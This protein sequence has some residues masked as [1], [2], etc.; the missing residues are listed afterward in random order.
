MAGRA[1]RTYARDSRGR[2][3][4]GGGGGG[5]GKGGGKKA[6][7]SAKP[8]RAAGQS[9]GGT[10]SARS[11]LRKSREKLA[12]N[13]TKAQ[14][15]AVT[16]ASNRLAKAKKEA[17]V[18]LFTRFK[19]SGTMRGKV[20]RDPGAL[21][22]RNAQ[23][24][25]VAKSKAGQRGKQLSRTSKAAPSAAK[26]RYKELSTTIRQGNRYWNVDPNAGRAAGGA[27]RSMAAMV[28]NRGRGKGRK[29]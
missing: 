9:Y 4:S 8:R 13:P 2:F 20:K 7:S 23:R 18:D 6:A 11:S 27:K 19:P 5:G 1:G 28:K 22:R 16:R 29:R 24:A 14:K 17:R 12:A 21:D 25:E 15:G 26:A 3:A 10:L